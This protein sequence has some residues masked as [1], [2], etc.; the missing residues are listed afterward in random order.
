MT[1]LHCPPT[2]I[3]GPSFHKYSK[4][5]TSKPL[6]SLGPPPPP[7]NLFHPSQLHIHYLVH[8]DDTPRK[9]I[10]P[11]H[12]EL[13]KHATAHTGWNITLPLKITFQS[14]I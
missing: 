10:K 11:Y 9:N 5:S 13:V 14:S 8:A 4:V 12:R 3:L 2:H 6:L 7:L 1:S